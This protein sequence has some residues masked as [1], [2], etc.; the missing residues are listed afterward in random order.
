MAHVQTYIKYIG[1]RLKYYYDLRSKDR[2]SGMGDALSL[3]H[4]IE[5]GKSTSFGVTA[6]RKARLT[7]FPLVCLWEEEEV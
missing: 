3:P 7:S 1:K 2:Q 6:I 5:I 4:N